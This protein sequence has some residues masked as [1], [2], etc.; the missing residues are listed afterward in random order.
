MFLVKNKIKKSVSV[1]LTL[2]MLLSC[3]VWVAPHELIQV[4]A[5]TDKASSITM[6]DFKFIVPE[7]IYLYPEALSRA[8]TTTTPFQY[9]VNNTSSGTACT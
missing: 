2:V 7:V 3:W 8:Q 9:Y 4:N 5:A 1:F 6:S